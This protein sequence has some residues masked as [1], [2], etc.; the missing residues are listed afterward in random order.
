MEKGVGPSLREARSRRRLSLQ[1]VEAATKIRMRY[2]KALESEDWDELPGDVYARA[3]VRTYAAYLGLDA[4]RLAEAMRRDRGAA[5]PGERLPRMEPLPQR[6]ARRRSG[7][8]SVS[9]RLLAA[10]VSVL[11]VAALIVVGVAGGGGSDDGSGHAQKAT[12]KG[13]QR[14]EGKGERT[15]PA[16]SGKRH[17]LTLLARG[18]VWVCLLDARGQPL[19]DGE[20]LAAG[21]RVGP[22]R[23]GSFSAALGNGQVSMELDGKQ[24]SVA[25]SNGPVGFS[26]NGAGAVSEIPEGER[27]TCT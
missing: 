23:S 8:P 16:D 3:F 25:P 13:H 17:E 26:V 21:A 15:A 27:P 5:R 22:F 10:L 6:A 9:P 2:L 11:V 20:I 18:E 14:S 4:D 24:T 7:G 19:V 12:D 1:E